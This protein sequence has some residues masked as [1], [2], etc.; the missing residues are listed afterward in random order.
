[1]MLLEQRR[2]AEIKC[3]WTLRCTARLYRQWA[4]EPLPREKRLRYRNE[5]ERYDRL[6]RSHFRTACN[7]FAPWEAS[8]AG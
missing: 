3:A 5:A 6:S 2:R 7:L 4:S 8:D 1:M